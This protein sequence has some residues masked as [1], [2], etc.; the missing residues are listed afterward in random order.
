[1]IKDFTCPIEVT[2]SLIGGKYKS[3]IM[4]HLIEDTLRFSELKRKIPK[5]TPKM[6]TQQLRELEENN[7]IIRTVYPVVPPKVE[8][9]LSEFGRSMVPILQAMFT[10]GD[11]YLTSHNIEMPCQIIENKVK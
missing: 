10:W 4:W 9:K 3:L 1:M 8:Y 11:A 6:M 5:S 2:I 7:L